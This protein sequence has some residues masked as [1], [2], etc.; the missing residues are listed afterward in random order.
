MIRNLVLKLFIAANIFSF[1]EVFS[2]NLFFIGDKSY[3]ITEFQDLTT[4]GESSFS[5]FSELKVAIGKDGEK[6][7]I[8][9]SKSDRLLNTKIGGEMII[10][11]DDGT[12]I[13]CIDRGV[14]DK[15]NSVI[16]SVYFLTPTEVNK[17]KG[18]NINT[19][20]YSLI[21]PGNNE[22]RAAE[23]V[24]KRLSFLGVE[25]ERVN[26]PILIMDLFNDM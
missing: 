1:N 7:L 21:A 16:T 11:L 10:Y 17:L 4:K 3:K 20:R 19:I 23:N 9:L 6:G 14:N 18:V 26:F 13:R 22:A 24:R 8:I 12:L 2:Q 25:I 15:V 5:G